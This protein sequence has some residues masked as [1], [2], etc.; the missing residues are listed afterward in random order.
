MCLFLEPTI[1]GEAKSTDSRAMGSW[2]DGRTHGR[3]FEKCVFQ[4][5]LLRTKSNKN[6]VGKNSR[7][8]RLARTKSIPAVFYTVPNLT[9]AADTS[10]PPASWTT[11]VL[12]AI[13]RMDDCRVNLPPPRPR[14]RKRR[15]PADATPSRADHKKPDGAPGRKRK[16]AATK[17][18]RLVV[19]PTPDSRSALSK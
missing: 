14:N 17:K 7:A 4:N 9:G 12:P 6:G 15:N 8:F 2:T 10:E 3:N 13:M 16:V 11:A 19:T 18:P 1:F 5:P